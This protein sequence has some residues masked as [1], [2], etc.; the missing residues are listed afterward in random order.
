MD[1]RPGGTYRYGALDVQSD[2]FRE[3]A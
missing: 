2:D 1:R 3:V